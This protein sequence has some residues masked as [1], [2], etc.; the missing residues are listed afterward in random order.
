M[1]SPRDPSRY[2]IEFRLLFERAAAGESIKIPSSNP[3]SLRSRLY[4]YARSLRASG[5]EDLAN[6]VQI[7]TEG[8]ILYVESR[9][10]SLAA[11]E[12]TAALASSPGVPIDSP[13]SLFERLAK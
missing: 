6:S 11:K 10:G 1:P 3:Y 4:G 2:P 8:K 9:S 7:R 13:D 12:I 5:Q